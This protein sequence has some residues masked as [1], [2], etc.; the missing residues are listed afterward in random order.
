MSKILYSRLKELG[1]D[2]IRYM[3]A[4]DTNGLNNISAYPEPFP[5]NNATRTTSWSH[6]LSIDDYVVDFCAATK[7]GDCSDTIIFIGPLPPWLFHTSPT[8]AAVCTAT[9]SNQCSGSL[10]DPSGAEAGEYFSRVI[11][12]FCKGGFVDEFGVKHTSGH[13]FNFTLWEVLNEANGYSH[14]QQ[15][16]GFIET[17]TQVYDGITTVLHRDH[18]ALQFVALCYGGIPTLPV[19]QYFMNDSNHASAALQANWPPAFLTFHIYDSWGT[20]GFVGNVTGVPGLAPGVLSAAKDAAQFIITASNGV[21]K[22][23]VDE[24]GNFGPDLDYETVLDDKPNR[25]AF[26]N[27]RAAWYAAAYGQLASVGVEMMGAS[28]FFGYNAVTGSAVSQNIRCAS[29][30]W[31]GM[32][33]AEPTCTCPQRN[34]PAEPRF[35]HGHGAFWYY[36]FLTA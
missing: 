10:V 31:I 27:P 13:H 3:Q 8:N 29:L 28:Q 24:M 35:E 14:W 21:T 11:S 5:P 12:W 26:W 4:Q 19:L 25:F 7:N 18:P 34:W 23:A 2:H 20:S 30:H 15:P 9:D 17:Y 16:P 32:S 36:D 33:V 6:L 1:T 22:P